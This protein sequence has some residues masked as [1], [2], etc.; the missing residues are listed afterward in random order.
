MFAGILFAPIGGASAQR[1]ID[2]LP[3]WGN[4]RPWKTTAL[5]PNLGRIDATDDMRPGLG[6]SGLANLKQF[7][8]AGGL[9][10]TAEATAKFAIDVGLAPGVFVPPSHKLKVVGSVLQ[11]KFIDRPNPIPPRSPPDQ[12]APS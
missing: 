2:G 5:T 9:L 11:A 12:Q 6:A 3:M 8:Q 10:V 1:I 7:V 4:P